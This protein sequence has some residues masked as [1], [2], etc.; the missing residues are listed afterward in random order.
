MGK[1]VTINGESLTIPTNGD[2]DWG[3][4][5]LAFDEAVV[6][7]LLDLRQNGVDLNGVSFSDVGPDIIE[8]ASYSRVIHV[9]KLGNDSTGDGTAALPYLT[10]GKAATEQ[11]NGELVYVHRGTYRETVAPGTGAASA[12]RT[13][14]GER[15]PGGEYLV[16]VDPSTLLAVTW[17][18]APEVGANVW[19]CVLGFN[20]GVITYNGKHIARFGD[21]QFTGAPKPAHAFLAM[22]RNDTVV[23][24]DLAETIEFWDV[25]W[26]LFGY[27]AAVGGGTTY[28][29]FRDGEDPNSLDLYASQLN[30]GDW[31]FGFDCYEASYVTIRDF[32]VRGAYACVRISDAHH[33]TIERCDLRHGLHRIYAQGTPELGLVH[34]CVIRDNVMTMDWYGYAAPGAWFTA[35]STYDLGLKEYVY[36]FLKYQCGQTNTADVS[37]KAGYLG[38]DCVIEDNEIFG[39]GEGIFL[40][41][42]DNP[43]VSG[44][45]LHDLSDLGILL[46]S[47]EQVGRPDQP[48]GATIH[49]NR[50]RNCTMGIRFNSVDVAEPGMSNAH[51]IYENTFWNPNETGEHLRF[52]FLHDGVGGDPDTQV[53]TLYLRVYHNN[54]GACKQVLGFNGNTTVR[55]GLPSAH[56]KNNVL[57][58]GALLTWLGTGPDLTT[59]LGSTAYMGA[60]QYNWCADDLSTVIAW[61]G[62]TNIIR[63]GADFWSVDSEPTWALPEVSEARKAGANLTGLPGLAAGYFSGAAPDMGARLAPSQSSGLDLLSL[64]SVSRQ[65]REAYDGALEL[66]GF[67]GLRLPSGDSSATPGEARV[68][69]P[70]GRSAIAAGAASVTVYNSR[71]RA[72]SLIRA[73]VQQTAADAT[74]LRVERTDAAEGSFTIY[75]NAAATAAVTVGWEILN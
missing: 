39:G 69:A 58:N 71:C 34:D 56:F 7:D 63:R 12:L 74:L 46:S 38:P 16:T 14:I 42:C 20:P 41:A 22:G 75:G 70:T 3:R 45:H 30:G 66:V 13:F 5:R 1:T 47:A 57:G 64:G 24:A 61:L 67:T 62:A 8:L 23:T 2:V 6:A 49:N 36:T 32:A 40:Y 11:A 18:A 44:N 26:A 51:Y 72:D 52:H 37:I 50:F 48:S 60:F 65:A 9:D 35:S 29:R 53:Q 27:D 73:W 10:I 25:P 17:L 43:D 21:D 68:E 28:I 4:N 31:T 33:V 54:F 59:F 15:G 55:G 19:K